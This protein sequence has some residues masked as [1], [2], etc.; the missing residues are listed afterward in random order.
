MHYAH[1][2]YQL[3]TSSRQTD[4]LGISS[5]SSTATEYSQL[6][7]PSYC[8]SIFLEWPINSMHSAGE[9]GETQQ[10]DQLQVDN[11][12]YEYLFKSLTHS[13]T[14]LFFKS[15]TMRFVSSV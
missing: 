7:A 5:S 10:T 9:G 15:P 3:L 11:M 1:S 12:A 14:W 8:S 2:H 6:T 4:T 13:L